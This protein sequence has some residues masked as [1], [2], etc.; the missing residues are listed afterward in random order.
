MKGEQDVRP[1]YLNRNYAHT[2]ILQ[3]VTRN[4]KLETRFGRMMPSLLM[5]IGVSDD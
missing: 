1:F 5:K 4:S 3:L 2:L